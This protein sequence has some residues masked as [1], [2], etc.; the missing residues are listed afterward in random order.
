MSGFLSWVRFYH[1]GLGPGDAGPS[2]AGLGHRPV[3]LNTDFF[4]I[5]V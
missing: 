5:W 3:G 2:W 1:A 4:Y